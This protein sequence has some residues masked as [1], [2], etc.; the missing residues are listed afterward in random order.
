MGMQGAPLPIRTDNR[1]SRGLPI[2][3]QEEV[4]RDARESP[5]KTLI[6][7]SGRQNLWVAPIS[8]ANFRFSF[9]IFLSSS[10]ARKKEQ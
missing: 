10:L 9:L 4:S 1:N 5:K 6:S 3:S 2:H 7:V 8:Y